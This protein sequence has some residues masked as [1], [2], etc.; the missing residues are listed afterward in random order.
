MTEDVSD[1]QYNWVGLPAQLR[2]R[3]R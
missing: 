1:G 3:K 2:K